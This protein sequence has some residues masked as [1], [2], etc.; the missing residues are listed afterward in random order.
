ML[1]SSNYILFTALR[2][3][4]RVPFVVVY[5]E[6]GARLVDQVISPRQLVE[7]RGRLRL[8]ATYYITKQVGGKE[9]EAAA[10][11]TWVGWCHMMHM[12]NTTA[13]IIICLHAYISLWSAAQ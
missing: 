4:E 8:N 2:Y 6:P 5:G 9:R 12:P 11:F 3:G 7:S 1:F 13:C 10:V